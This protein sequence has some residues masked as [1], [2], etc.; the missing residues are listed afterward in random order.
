MGRTHE[1]VGV[2]VLL[3]AGGEDIGLLVARP[4]A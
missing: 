3:P 2:P 4:G 1:V